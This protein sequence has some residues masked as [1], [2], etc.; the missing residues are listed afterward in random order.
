MAGREE[1]WTEPQGHSGI[2]QEAITK[3][4]SPIQRI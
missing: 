1:K 4:R 3:L 2:V